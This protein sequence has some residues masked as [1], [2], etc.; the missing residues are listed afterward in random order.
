[1]STAPGA[2]ETGRVIFDEE[3]KEFREGWNACHYGKHFLANPY[4][5]AFGG[6]LYRLWQAGYNLC[7][8]RWDTGPD[9]GLYSKHEIETAFTI[10]DPKNQDNG[11]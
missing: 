5:L 3:C 7:Q 6:E 11:K 2:N 10:T 9:P 8:E 1:M 4:G